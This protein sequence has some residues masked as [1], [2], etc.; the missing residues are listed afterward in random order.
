MVDEYII[1][2]WHVGSVFLRFHTKGTYEEL[3]IKDVMYVG[4]H[5][6][7]MLSILILA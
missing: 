2:V 7:N 1:K 4:D 5:E 3:F 6:F